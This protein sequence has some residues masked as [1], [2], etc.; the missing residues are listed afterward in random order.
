MSKSKRISVGFTEREH[1][2]LAD[3]EHVGISTVL[4]RI[5]RA[6]L[7]TGNVTITEPKTAPAAT[8]PAAVTGEGPAWLPPLD[9]D[10]R[11]RWVRDRAAAVQAMIDRYPP[12][13]ATLEEGWPRDAAVR[14][15]LWALTVWRDLLDTGTY[16]DPRMNSRTPARSPNSPVTSVIGHV[17]PRASAAKRVA[18][19][20]SPCV[21]RLRHLR[22]RV[23]QRH[24]CD[25]RLPTAMCSS[26]SEDASG[27]ASD[28]RTNP[29]PSWHAP[30]PS[31]WR[32]L[33]HDERATSPRSPGSPV[34][35]WSG[36]SR[37]PH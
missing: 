31:K 37:P 35:R 6:Q 12:E 25:G 15:Q 4:A 22:G 9:P 17:R 1:D 2:A 30:R 11:D 32:R 10:E 29:P 27:S 13:L 24:G 33:K 7:A 26:C 36:R 14:E 21:D 23:R 19:V 28:S 18:A 5:V 34:A 16:D 20:R 3:H 8:A